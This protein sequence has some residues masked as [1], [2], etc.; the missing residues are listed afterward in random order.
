MKKIL[1]AAAVLMPAIASAEAEL[2]NS[3]QTEGNGMLL[4]LGIGIMILMLL[5]M[6]VV[7]Y[8]GY[9]Y[10]QKMARKF[11]ENDQDKNS[12]IKVVGAGLLG[13]VA[14]LYAVYAF[15]GTI[16]SFLDSGA[17]GV[18][19]FKGTQYIASSYV[20]PMLKTIAGNVN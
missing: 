1:L 9:S 15:Y 4:A 16:G 11:I 5:F 2:A 18:D 6:F 19:F 12:G 14:G 8:F 17:T 7:P 10:G 3:I 20:D 13:I